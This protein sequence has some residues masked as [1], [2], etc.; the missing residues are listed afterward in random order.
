M[1]RNS[2]R[3]DI[4]ESAKPFSKK[5]TCEQYDLAVL[6]EAEFRKKYRITKQR[7]QELQRG[8]G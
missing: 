4:D 3:I 1:G 7:Y 8:R 5:V 6:S 2:H